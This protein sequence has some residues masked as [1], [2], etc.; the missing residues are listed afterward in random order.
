MA[1]STARLNVVISSYFFYKHIGL[2]QHDEHSTLPSFDL[3]F[4]DAYERQPCMNLEYEVTSALQQDYGRLWGLLAEFA[5][6]LP[7]EKDARQ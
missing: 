3:G 6:D 4:V 1:L 5:K 2:D 7:L